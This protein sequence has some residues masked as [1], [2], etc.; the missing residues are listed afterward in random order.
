[1]ACRRIS[2]LMQQLKLKI[3]N[4]VAIYVLKMSMKKDEPGSELLKGDN[5]LCK[6]DFLFCDLTHNSSFMYINKCLYL[7]YC[8]C[9]SMR[10]L[11]H[12]Q[13]H[14]HVWLNCSSMHS[15]LYFSTVLRNQIYVFLQVLSTRQGPQFSCVLWQTL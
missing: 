2:F 3:L 15:C 12:Y 4:T 10:L 5:H 9:L 11:Y 7:L 14:L 8:I 1:M 6:T 13:R